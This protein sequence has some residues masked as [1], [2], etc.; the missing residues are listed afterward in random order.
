MSPLQMIRKGILNNDLKG[1]IDGYNILSGESLSIKNKKL[2]KQEIISDQDIVQ[3]EN[4][5]TDIILDAEEVKNNL[6]RKIGLQLHSFKNTFVDDGK[7]AKNRF[8][9]KYKI[10]KVTQRR[11]PAKKFDVTCNKCHKNFKVY[12]KYL[13]VKFD[14]DD[15]SSYTCNNCIPK[16]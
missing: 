4:I 11:P 16:G 10:K 5:K 13:P 2:K 14:K 6:G 12:A 15:E 1:I 8:D 9:K 7:F 3:D